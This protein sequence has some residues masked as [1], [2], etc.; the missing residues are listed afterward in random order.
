MK[1]NLFV[2]NHK[3]KFINFTQINIHLSKHHKLPNKHAH[4][5]YLGLVKIYK[6]VKHPPPISSCTSMEMR[7]NLPD[8]SRTS[9]LTKYVH[10]GCP[11]KKNGVLFYENITIRGY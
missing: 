8:T 1:G 10:K 2:F 9:R 7:Q 5:P 3:P 11:R 4:E 6:Y